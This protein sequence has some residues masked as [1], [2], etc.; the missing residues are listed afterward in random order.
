[1]G[2]L[3]AATVEFVYLLVVLVGCLWDISGICCFCGFRDLSH[4]ILRHLEPQTVNS[5]PSKSSPSTLS[6]KDSQ[7]VMTHSEEESYIIVKL[8]SFLEEAR[9]EAACYVCE[10]W[11]KLFF[12]NMCIIW[13]CLPVCFSHTMKE[14]YLKELMITFSH[15]KFI[16]LRT[17]VVYLK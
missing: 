13:R 16:L 14:T 4:F 17:C 9:R 8:S 7:R 1:M 11:L 5:F 10:G 15:I 3:S 6:E 12:Y 2:P